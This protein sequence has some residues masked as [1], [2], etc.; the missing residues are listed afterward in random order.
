MIIC[1]CSPASDWDETAHA[2]GAPE[3][4]GPLKFR[5]VGAE[6]CGRRRA[7]QGFDVV[8]AVEVYTPART[9]KTCSVGDQSPS[10]VDFSLDTSANMAIEASGVHTL[11][12]QAGKK[13]SLWKGRSSRTWN[14]GSKN[15][16][17]EC[18][19]VYKWGVRI[20]A[21]ALKTVNRAV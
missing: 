7:V 10:V 5:V 9:L 14:A 12:A 21:V 16:S 2:V 13:K 17:F 20:R 6:A 15:R 4:M 1:S 19:S 11:Y 8:T 3:L 18:I